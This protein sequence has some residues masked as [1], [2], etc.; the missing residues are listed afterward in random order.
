LTAVTIQGEG[1]PCSEPTTTGIDFCPHS[2]F[3][4][5]VVFSRVEGADPGTYL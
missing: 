5:C 3:V 2:H 4:V 1:W